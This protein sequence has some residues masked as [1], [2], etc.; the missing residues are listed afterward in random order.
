MILD[1]HKPYFVLGWTYFYYPD[2]MAPARIEEYNNRTFT[3]ESLAREFYNK[4]KQDRSCTN[5][6]LYYIQSQKIDL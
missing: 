5:F 1:N 6:E 4:K 3:S 2:S